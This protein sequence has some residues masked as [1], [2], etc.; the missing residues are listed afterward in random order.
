[1]NYPEYAWHYFVK[2]ITLLTQP[3][4]KFLY[5]GAGYVSKR[6]IPSSKTSGYLQLSGRLT[7]PGSSPEGLVSR[8][9][10]ADEWKVVSTVSKEMISLGSN[11]GVRSDV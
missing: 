4:T 2:L 1:M 6:V 7:E 5:P 9:S 3:P 10:N 11:V 8:N